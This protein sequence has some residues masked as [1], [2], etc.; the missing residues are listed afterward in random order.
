MAALV[1]LLRFSLKISRQCQDL[2]L[3]PVDVGRDLLESLHLAG[4][5]GCHR[6]FAFPSSA[7]WGC[8]SWRA[9]SAPRV[10]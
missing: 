4:V 5:D 6:E 2:G 10:H 3:P 8:T 7:S 1:F 9:F